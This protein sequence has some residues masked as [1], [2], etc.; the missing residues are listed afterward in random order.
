MLAL[1][2]L[3]GLASAPWWLPALAGP[4]AESAATS[5]AGGGRAGVD[6][7]ELAWRA[8]LTFWLTL[9]N[10]VAVPLAIAW[11]ALELRRIA[12]ALEGGGRR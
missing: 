5:A 10:L 8:R 12:R 9:G 3:A 1:A 6:L 11:L 2:V 7:A 4:G